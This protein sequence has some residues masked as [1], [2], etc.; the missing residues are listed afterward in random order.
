MFRN[1]SSFRV[2]S[3]PSFQ[4]MNFFPRRFGATLPSPA[5]VAV[6]RKSLAGMTLQRVC[7]EAHSIQDLDLR[8]DSLVIV[9]VVS[10][11]RR[12][13]LLQIPVLPSTISTPE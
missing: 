12:R 1:K 10:R 9:F 2:T 4:R 7:F 11:T 13:F 5:P 3:L 8:F 6:S